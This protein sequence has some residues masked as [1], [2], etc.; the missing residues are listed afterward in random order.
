VHILD[1]ATD[2]KTFLLH[3]TTALHNT[4]TDLSWVFLVGDYNGDG[5][6]D[7]YAVNKNANGK[8][9]V[10]VLNGADNFKTFLLHAV[11]GSASM[12]TDNSQMLDLADYNGDGKLDLWTIAKGATGSGTTEVHILSGADNFKTYIAHSATG[13]HLTGTDG[14]WYFSVAD[15]NGDGRPDLYAIDKQDAGSGKTAVHVLNGADGFKTFLLH[16]ISPLGPT[17]TDH[18]WV[19]DL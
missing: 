5:R 1:G 4:G 19:F 8:T 13:L 12:G 17:G 16:A 11:S 15:Y 14:R 10:H 18:R 7:L 6:K 2:F 3:A 9:D